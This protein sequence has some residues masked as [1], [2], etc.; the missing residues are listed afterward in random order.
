[1]LNEKLKLTYGGHVGHWEGVLCKAQEKA[2]LANGGVTYDDKLEQVVVA[3]F[4]K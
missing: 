1:M 2:S 3:R 4:L